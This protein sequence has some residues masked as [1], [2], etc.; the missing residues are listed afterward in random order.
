[1]MCNPT[2]IATFLTPMSIILVGAVAIFGLCAAL[3]G[4]WCTA[5]GN[6]FLAASVAVMLGVALGLT[7][8]ALIE[9]ANCLNGPCA[10]AARSCTGRWS[11]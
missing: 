1:M 5:A 7:N 3:A 4:S 11:R 10:G 8:A 6:G 2:R 9:T